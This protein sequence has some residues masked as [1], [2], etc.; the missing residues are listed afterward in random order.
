MADFNG[1]ALTILHY[2]APGPNMRCHPVTARLRRRHT[3][4]PQPDRPHDVRHLCDFDNDGV[5][6]SCSD[7]LG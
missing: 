1:D 7:E 5:V 3:T 4:Q 2:G 6:M